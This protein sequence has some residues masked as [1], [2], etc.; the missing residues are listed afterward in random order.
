MTLATAQRFPL[1]LGGMGFYRGWALAMQ[2]QGEEGMAQ[3]HQG[4]AAVGPRGRLAAVLSGPARRGR[5]ARRPGRGRAAAA[6]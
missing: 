3:L 6:G 1:W 5:G 4:L 2:G